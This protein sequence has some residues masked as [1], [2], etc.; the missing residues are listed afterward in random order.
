VI[1]YSIGTLCQA[2]AQ[3]ARTELVRVEAKVHRRYFQE[4]FDHLRAQTIVIEPGYTDR[5]FLEDYAGYYVRCFGTEHS[6][7]RSR[8]TRMHFFGGA[9]DV[10]EFDH[11][12]SGARENGLAE[13]LGRYLGFIVVKPLPKTFIGRTC[14]TTYDDDGR[15][16]Y[17]VTRD[18]PVHLAGMSFSVRSLAFQEQDT[19]AAACATSALWSLFHGTGI[20]FHHALPSP[21][22]ITRTATEHLPLFGRDFPSSGLATVQMADAV[23][24]VG[25]QPDMVGVPSAAALQAVCYAYLKAGIPVLMNAL[26]YDTSC[27]VAAQADIVGHAVAVTGFRRGKL[28]CEPFGETGTLFTSARIDRLYVHDDQ[29]G[30]FARLELTSLPETLP[31]GQNVALKSSWPAADPCSGAVWFA[32][33]SLIVPL[34]HK[35]RI[36]LA[37]VRE[38]VIRLDR[39]FESARVEDS[40]HLEE[41]VEWDVFLAMGDQLKAD[42]RAAHSLAPDRLCTLLKRP[43]PRFV[44]RAIGRNQGKPIIEFVFDATDIEQGE[45]IFEVIDYGSL[46]DS[47]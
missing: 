20:L 32:P 10:A 8:C 15:R 2:F 31:S 30:P 26:L 13:T 23:R 14:L 27:Q 38:E 16:S 43:F 11:V 5:D 33:D 4:Y 24:R 12:L 45:Y 41:R 9:F 35:I 36:P 18:Y 21:S 6:K 44:W 19:I 37:T 28:D 25:L 39:A 17:P 3:Y 47:A 22:E 46:L 7:Y 42:L 34:Y 40:I 1:P 29:V